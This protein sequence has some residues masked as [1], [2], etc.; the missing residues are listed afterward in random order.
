MSATNASTKNDRRC[1][2]GQAI[3]GVVNTKPIPAPS[4]PIWKHQIAV[5]TRNQ[6]ERLN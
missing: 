2:I 4:H 3:L 1:H 5:A 6:I